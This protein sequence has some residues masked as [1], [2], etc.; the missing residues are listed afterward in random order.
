M[1]FL[2]FLLCFV[3][4]SVNTYAQKIQSA[5]LM[6]AGLTCSMC[7][8]AIQKSLTTLSFV[9]SVE[10]DLK[11]AAFYLKFKEQE[12]V[13]LALVRDK[14]EDAGFS[15]AALKIKINSTSALDMPTN[16]LQ[17]HQ[18]Y[19]CIAIPGKPIPLRQSYDLLLI[20]RGFTTE[21]NQKQYQK[22]IKEAQ[23]NLPEQSEPVLYHV[24]VAE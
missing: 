3:F 2:Q 23:C 9:E 15:I 11:K 6:A 19:F 12:S 13:S 7:S 8:N 4:F 17:I 24:I 14:V 18:Q 20:N 22:I 10:P 5:E 16:V 1:K 21:K